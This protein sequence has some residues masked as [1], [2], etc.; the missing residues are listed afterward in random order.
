MS[1]LPHPFEVSAPSVE[2]PA[3]PRPAVFDALRRAGRIA[4]MCALVLL[5]PGE[6][7]RFGSG[8]R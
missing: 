4:A 2:V 6:A 5:V 7:D 8:T 1:A 3:V